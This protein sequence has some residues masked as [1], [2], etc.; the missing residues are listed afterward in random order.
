MIT[1]EVVA[2][3]VDTIRD[4]GFWDE[5]EIILK[6]TKPIILWSN[7]VMVKAQEWEKYMGRWIVC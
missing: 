4:D 7:F 6:I 5:V 3:L 1:V 2:Q